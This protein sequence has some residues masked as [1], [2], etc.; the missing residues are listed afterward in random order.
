MAHF[1]AVIKGSRGVASRLGTKRS[2]I[3]ALVQTW[4]WD[5]SVTVAHVND[6]HGPIDECWRDGTITWR[7]RTMSNLDLALIEL[8]NHS[9]GERKLIATV[10]LSTGKVQND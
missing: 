3:S 6:T 4:G 10:N 7:T 2:G 8:V 1:R 9:T 5:V